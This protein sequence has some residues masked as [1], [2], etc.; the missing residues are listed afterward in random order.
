MAIFRPSNINKR[1]VGTAGTT[2]GSPGNGGQIG[3]KKTLLNFLPRSY[4]GNK[5]AIT[6]KEELE[7]YV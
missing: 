1:L 3:P 2:G 5:I 7:N 4:A 6:N